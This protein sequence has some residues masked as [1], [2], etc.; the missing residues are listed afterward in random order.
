MCLAANCSTQK[1]N[2]Q[3]VGSR[4]GTSVYQTTNGPDYIRILLSSLVNHHVTMLQ[5]LV[6]LTCV[7]MNSIFRCR[8]Y[9]A[10][11]SDPSKDSNKGAI[12]ENVRGNSLTIEEFQ[13]WEV[14]TVLGNSWIR[15]LLWQAGGTVKRLTNSSSIIVF[16]SGTNRNKEKEKPYWIELKMSDAYLQFCVSR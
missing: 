2:D 3:T 4:F 12:W 14:T 11:D 5:I 10:T 15:K 6:S 13:L 8:S 1:P 7:T 9:I 16:T